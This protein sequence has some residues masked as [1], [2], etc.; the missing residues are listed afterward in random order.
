[1]NQHHIPVIAID[2]TSSSG[3]GTVANLPSQYF[4]FHYLNS[5]ALYRLSAFLAI[6]NGIDIRI[7]DE[8]NLNQ[9]VS[10][11]TNEGSNVC[12]VGSQVQYCGEDLWPV[13]SSQEAGNNAAAISF[14]PPLR[15]AIRKFQ[16][17]RILGPGLVA[18][19]RDMGTTVFSD[20]VAKIYLDASIEAR[21][22]RRFS[23]E[24]KRYSGKTFEGICIELQNRDAIDKGHTIGT[25]K[26]A[27]DA[28][29]IDTSHLTSNE[30]LEMC[31]QFCNCKNIVKQA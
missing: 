25:L 10:I 28:L 15:Y 17:S 29:F 23:D 5:G 30:V 2:G 3:K 27:E 9:I 7:H 6:R 18:E 8:E 1:M 20:A 31:I 26:Q 14:Y 11:M 4:G 22:K 12:F 16:R 21:A 24:E 19:G 13:L